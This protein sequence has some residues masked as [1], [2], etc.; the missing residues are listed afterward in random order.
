MDNPA[1][2]PSSEP[3]VCIFFCQNLLADEVRTGAYRYLFHPEEF[4]TGK[5]DAANNYGRG[6][7]TVRK[8]ILD[9]V[10][11]R[12]R[13]LVSEMFPQ[14]SAADLMPPTFSVLTVRK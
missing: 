10:L 4:I 3:L 7:Y 14:Y 13:K 5:E 12:I 2:A 1:V 11:D 9:L 6:H 8:E